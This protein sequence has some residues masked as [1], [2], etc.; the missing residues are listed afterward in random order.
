MLHHMYRWPTLCAQI[1]NRL[2]FPEAIMSNEMILFCLNF[3]PDE[4]SHHLY[5]TNLQGLRYWQ[6]LNCCVHTSL[7]FHGPYLSRHLYSGDETC[8]NFPCVMCRWQ[9]YY[10]TILIIVVI[11]ENVGAWN[12]S[13]LFPQ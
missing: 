9:K 8:N 12:L 6:I 5:V 4:N 11:I 2:N 7:I 13:G 1:A 10:Q 3:P